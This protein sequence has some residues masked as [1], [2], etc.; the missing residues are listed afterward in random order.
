MAPWLVACAF[1]SGLIAA[2]TFEHL[3]S[4]AVQS[5]WVDAVSDAWLLAGTLSTVAALIQ[6]AGASAHFTPWI[7]YTEIGTAFA[8]LRQ[9][10]QFASLTT[11]ALAALLC[12]SSRERSFTRQA[13]A[14]GAALL[15]TVIL[16]LGNAASSSRTGLVQIGVVIALNGVWSGLRRPM[17]CRILITFVAAYAAALWVLP[18]SIGLDPF[19]NSAWA[20]LQTGDAICSSRITLWRNVLHLIELRPW[21]GWGWGELDYA[22]F[23]TPYDGPRFCDILDNAHNLP[24]HLAVELG[25]PV[26]VGV[27]AVL[28]WLVVRASPWRE[29]DPT[30]QMAW[31]VL[32]LIGLHSLLEYPLWYGPFQMA[33]GLCIL[34]LWRGDSSGDTPRAARLKRAGCA[35]LAAVL[36]AVCAYVGWDYW[37]ISQIYLPPDARAE[38][39]RGDTLAK[40]R[41]SW[42]FA[43]QVKFAEL[44]ITPLT[45]DNA[46][47]QNTLAK[48]LLHFSP[49]PRVIEKLI[50]SA[51]LLHRYDEAR[52]TLA[53]F[54]A[55]FPEA[56]DRWAAMNPLPF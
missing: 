46:E 29:T 55:V 4:R 52:I 10:N 25:I 54:R 30:R 18:W 34:L 5:S 9:R 43:D 16:A 50:E 53:Q 21:F 14:H 3:R 23:V 48:E 7:N 13:D 37:R 20:R 31:T 39:Y 17:L 36:L 26:A 24:L 41:G 8:N 28:T 27:C 19:S 33:V 12:W 2:Q 56:H 51:L 42:L 44:T 35:A 38:A 1:S 40:I 45:L 49:E 15:M 32:A 22:H 11:I 6:Y 47:H